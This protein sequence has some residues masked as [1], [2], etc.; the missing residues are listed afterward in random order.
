M[1]RLSFCALA[2]E[3]SINDI[4]GV[5]ELWKM[6]D[7]TNKVWSHGQS[8]F[9]FGFPWNRRKLHR[10]CENLIIIVKDKNTF[11]VYYIIKHSRRENLSSTGEADL[12]CQGSI[13]IIFYA[14]GR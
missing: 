6:S 2:Q 11:V 12:F 13:P 8:L 9:F 10:I 5:K 3:N 7:K 1:G 14:F 4:Q